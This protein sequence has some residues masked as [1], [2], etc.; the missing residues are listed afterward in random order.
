MSDKKN[1]KKT[2]QPVK[3]KVSSGQDRGQ[4]KKLTPAMRQYHQVKEK[5]P[6][7]LLLFQMGDFYETFYQDAIELA[8]TLNI[9]LTTRGK[10]GPE[11]IPL[12]GFPIKALDGY[13]PKL[14]SFGH[15]V[16]L[17]DQTEDPKHAKGVVKR[18]VVRVITPGTILEE[19]LLDPHQANHIAAMLPGKDGYGFAWVELTTGSFE[20]ANIQEKEIPILLARIDP[21]EI[22]IPDIFQEENAQKFSILKQRYDI[23]YSLF[24][25]WTFSQRESRKTLQ[26]HFGV[27]SLAGFGISQ[28]ESLEVAAAGAL[29]AYLKEQ[30]KSELTHISKLRVYQLSETIALD[31][32]TVNALEIVETMRSKD[33]KHTLFGVLN[34]CSTS[35]GSRLL[36]SW[37]LAPLKEYDQI[38]LRQE[39]VAELY[40]VKKR[41]EL[42]IAELEKFGDLERL[43]GR[44]G[45]LR[46]MPRDLIALMESLRYVPLLANALSGVESRLLNQIAERL[47]PVEEASEL[48]AKAFDSEPSNVLKEGG[49]IR[50]GFHP[51]LDEFRSM[52]REGRQYIARFQQKEAEESDIPS[53]KVGY[54]SVFGYYLEITNVHKDKAPAHWIR[55]QTLKNAERYITPELKE[56]EAKVLN[57]EGQAIALEQRLFLEIREELSR[58]AA[59]ISATAHQLALLDVLGNFAELAS[60]RGYVQPEFVESNQLLLEEGRHPVLEQTLRDTQVVPNACALNQDSTMALITGPNMAGKSTYIRMVALLTLMA[61]AGSFVPA[62]SLRLGV[63]DTIF[64]RIGSADEIQKGNSTFMVEMIETANILNNATEQSLI[65]LDEVGRGTSTFDG[66]SIAW[67]ITEYLAQ[68]LKARTLFATHY[69]ELTHLAKQISTVQNLNVSVRE[70]GDEIIFLHKIVGGA[71]DRSYGIQV[72]RLAGLPLDVIR[73]SKQILKGLEKET[74]QFQG[75]AG[76][77]ASQV[78]RSKLVQL[79]LFSPTENQLIQALENIDPDN[80]P[81]EVLKAEI[82]RLKALAQSMKGE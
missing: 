48:I 61:Q 7:A 70:W 13:L 21:A 11:P 82:S 34:K 18:E 51:E 8:S 37:L 20:L 53:L 80:L 35:M 60:S 62:D 43:A 67:A 36:R 40:H 72:A 52:Q 15:R 31:A 39:A 3:D 22:V 17:C 55:K 49:I 66:V 71:A 41:R 45:C 4:E 38:L 2:G 6:D 1:H 30:Q 81:I 75:G 77:Q 19:S 14:V 69:H 42:M 47:D 27:S 64:T 74:A 46:A 23:P 44:L 56:I 59:R 73:R 50:D 76:G 58:Y 33:R 32:A 25:D 79:M 12:A 65:V 63:V 9:T 28:E 68:N 5:H 24:P 10:D 57:A 26:K 54:N 16:V 78:K 29:L